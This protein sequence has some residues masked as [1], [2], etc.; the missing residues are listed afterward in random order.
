MEL[1]LSKLSW[2]QYE[3][4]CARLLQAQG[5]SI[6]AQSGRSRD[7]GVDLLVSPAEGG[8][9]WV[10]EWK[11][12]RRRTAVSPLIRKAVRQ[13]LAYQELL[14]AHRALLIVP[15][16]LPPGLADWIGQQG[17]FHVWD[18]DVLGQILEEHPSIRAE[19]ASLVAAQAGGDVET[20]TPYVRDVRAQQLAEDLDSMPC[21]SDHW[22]SFE[23]L[24]I[25]ILNH[26]F[27]PPL[28]APRIHSRSEDR[29]DIR[30]ALYPIGDG[31]RSW[32]TL[33]HEC[34]TRVLVAEFK[35]HCGLIGQKEV[36]SLQQYL[37]TKA[38]R[39]LGILCCRK[40]PSAP[41][42]AAR[43]R[44]WLEFD[45]LIVILS[46]IDLKELLALKATGEDPT[47]AIDEQLDSF[48]ADL[49]P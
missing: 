20:A 3:L 27:I 1:D 11:Q 37:F 49:S 42:L 5:F 32:D 12:T 25:D 4:L 6:L 28:R 48:F 8:E 21:G 38:M 7:I 19:F 26:L 13:L 31:S 9:K 46:D 22:S 45:K 47:Q 15:S 17:H 39:S 29:L 10:V 33:R 18:R 14:G 16:D 30:D 44:A 35:N 43:R 40:G 41:A 2:Q 23:D 34:R 36:E 24:C